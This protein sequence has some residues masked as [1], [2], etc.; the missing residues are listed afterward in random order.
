MVIETD[1][2]RKE[3]LRHS[4][5]LASAPS[6]EFFLPGDTLPRVRMQPKGPQRKEPL[7][8]GFTTVTLKNLFQ[9]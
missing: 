2:L 9:S 4:G 1:L 7:D 6:D 3:F 8:L 5:P